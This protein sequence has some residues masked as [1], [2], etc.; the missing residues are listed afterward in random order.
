M[1]VRGQGRRLG[2]GRRHRDEGENPR[3]TNAAQRQR[4]E[5]NDGECNPT[6]VDRTQQ[7]GFEHDGEYSHHD[8]VLNTRVGMAQRRR[9]APQHNPQYGP[10]P[11]PTTRSQGTTAAQGRT[12]KEEDSGGTQEVEP[13]SPPNIFSHTRP[14]SPQG[15]RLAPRRDVV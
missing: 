4:A 11:T 15:C 3:T 8:G 1:R 7:R 5:P 6:A 10:T 13:T 14:S 9:F 12:R 2:Q